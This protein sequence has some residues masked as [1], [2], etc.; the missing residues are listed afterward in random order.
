[1]VSFKAPFNGY[2]VQFSPYLE[3]RVAVATAQNFGIIGNGKQ[4]VLELTPNGLLEVAAF[5]TSDGLYD[6]A[7]SEENENVLA[8]ASGDGSV[9]VWD[10]QAPP[11]LNPI[12]SFEEHG[13]EVYCVSW[14]LVRRD[15]FLSASWDDTIKLWDLRHPGSVRTFAEHTY[16]VYSAA[17]S[18]VNSEAFASASGDCTVKIWDLRRPQSTSTFRA[19]DFEILSLDWCKYNDFVLAT[20]SVDKSIRVWDIRSPTRPVATLQG[21]TYAVRR[22]V[23]SAHHETLLGSCSAPARA[24][25]TLD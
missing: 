20:G 24:S 14:N 19:H 8:S 5:D 9:K 23:F 11:D 16:C 13:H 21:H 1:M 4:H 7:W 2:S 10:L 12:R 18:P 15:C 17:W 6:C 25:T 22:V 3:G